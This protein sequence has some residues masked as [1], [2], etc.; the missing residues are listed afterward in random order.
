MHVCMHACMHV[1]MHAFIE[2]T[3]CYSR[4]KSGRILSVVC[5]N[6]M[7]L[8]G[9]YTQQIYAAVYILYNIYIY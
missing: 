2:L 3:H 7:R 6:I 4:P 9:I 1:C 8:L 5:P